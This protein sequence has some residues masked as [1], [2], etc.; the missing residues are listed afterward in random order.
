MAVILIVGL[1]G[2]AC[3]SEK[4]HQQ[5]STAREFTVVAGHYS[6]PA[7]P[8]SP[9]AL[10]FFEAPGISETLYASIE[11]SSDCIST[12]I[13]KI[14][15]SDLSIMPIDTL[16]AFEL[17]GLKWQGKCPCTYYEKDLS[18]ELTVRAAVARTD[19]GTAVLAL[20][21]YRD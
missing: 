8:C 4:R 5:L 1:F 2:T 14:G 13:K 7:L 10:H 18:N 21:A 11:A 20:G 19:R 9:A 12:Y 17:E 3:G 16:T 6:L 15:M